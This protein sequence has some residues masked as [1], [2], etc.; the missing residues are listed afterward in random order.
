MKPSLGGALVAL[1]TTAASGASAP[2][3]TR[4]VGVYPGDPRE[5]AAP[6]LVLDTTSY[7]NLARHRPAYHSSSRDYNLT[8]QLVTDGIEAQGA[9]RWLEVTTSQRGVAPKHERELVVDHNWTSTV[10]LDAPLAWVQ[11]QLGG[12][13]APPRFDRVVLEVR[14]KRGPGARP[15]G[16]TAPAAQW[17]WA[18][19]LSDD[20]RTWH[21][22]GRTSG[23]LPP[24]PPPPTTGG[25]AAIGEWFRQANP[26]LRPEVPLEAPV[27]ARF[28][29]VELKA[30]AGEE[31]SLSEV[32]FRDQGRP[33]EVG[34][35][36]DFTS[37]W[38]PA[39]SGEEW[40][41]VDLGAPCTFD[42]IALHW[43]HRAAAGTLQVS[44]DGAQWRDLAPL[45]AGA[46]P[47]DDV[48]LA[49]PA[50]A[51][52]VRVLLTRPASPAGYALGELQVFG[53]GGPVARAEARCRRRGPTA[54]SSSRA[55]PGACSAARSWPRT[56]PRSRGPA[57]P[58]GT[59]SPPPC[60]ARCSRAT[61]TS[62]RFP[63]RT[64]ATTS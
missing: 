56:A 33:V 42:R 27:Q 10:E 47:A 54:G 4:G 5:D 22:A 18:V 60:R 57:S 36:Y 24:V 28:V 1:L 30:A 2:P 59:G 34:G 26:T 51:R 38:M 50:Q 9:P 44:D 62:G 52:W 19:S 41:S 32:A 61:G 16:R 14:P 12:G 13:E 55:A 45:P 37:A 11:L 20:G 35:P 48:R 64:S 6:R 7:R 40:V 31:W 23:T 21:E 49:S 58:T 15:A 25:F 53:R 17:T 43:V 46:G 3:A 8:A 63:I 39:G 29:R